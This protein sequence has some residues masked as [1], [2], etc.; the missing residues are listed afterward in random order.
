MQVASVSLDTVITPVLPRQNCDAVWE[1][2]LQRELSA[3]AKVTKESHA[4]EVMMK[5]MRENWRFKRTTDRGI[6]PFW[7]KSTAAQRGSVD[8][9]PSLHCRMAIWCYG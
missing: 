2:N 6:M 3:E 7:Y 8:N 5:I 1:G 9:L 4:N